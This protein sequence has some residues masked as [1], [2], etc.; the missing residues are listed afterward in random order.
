M[1]EAPEATSPAEAETSSEPETMTAAEPETPETPEVSAPVE[2][3]VS[4]APEPA[5]YIPLG[6]TVY[7][8]TKEYELLA[9]GGENVTLYDPDCPLFHEIMPRREFEA[10]LSENPLNSHLFA[11]D[12]ATPESAA[13]VSAPERAEPGAAPAP[14]VFGAGKTD[15][16]AVRPGV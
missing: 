4:A 10:K 7:I 3:E 6:S 11:A 14:R 12:A 9:Y 2:Q 8:G 16:A 1:Q 5:H 13:Q 15:C